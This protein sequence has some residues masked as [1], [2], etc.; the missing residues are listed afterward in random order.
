MASLPLIQIGSTARLSNRLFYNFYK[1]SNFYEFSAK[2]SQ[3]DDENA[4]TGDRICRYFCRH[5]PPVALLYR[6]ATL[7][8]RIIST[9]HVPLVYYEHHTFTM[10]HPYYPPD[11]QLDYLSPALS[12]EIILGAMGAVSALVLLLGWQLMSLL[13]PALTTRAKATASWFL[14]CGLL[15]IHFEGYF[16]KYRHSLA[17]RSDVIG[18]LWKEYALSDSRYLLGAKAEGEFVVGIEALTVV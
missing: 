2:Q 18:E 13:N 4:V 10:T 9:L 15:H 5:I 1:D 3:Y 16:I 11:M 6:V 17:S 8:F 7:H 14:Y 12:K